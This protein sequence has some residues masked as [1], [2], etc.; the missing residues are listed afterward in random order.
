VFL[1]RR[2]VPGIEP[3]IRLSAEG[4]VGRH[5]GRLAVLNPVYEILTAS[6]QEGGATA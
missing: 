1:G 3:G 6:R 4:M 2:S 5:N